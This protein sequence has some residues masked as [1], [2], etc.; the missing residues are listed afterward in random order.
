MERIQSF[1]K[2]PERYKAIVF[3]A[4]QIN[5][6]Q[7]TPGNISQH[8]RQWMTTTDNT[9][10]AEN[11]S[12]LGSVS[13]YGATSWKCNKFVADAYASTKG[14]GI[15][16]KYPIKKDR[17]GQRWCPQANELASLKNFTNFPLEELV[18]IAKD[19]KS[20]VEINEYDNNGNAVAKYRLEGQIFRKYVKQRRNW[21]QTKITKQASEL[22]PGSTAN[23]GDIVSFHNV[24]RGVSGHTGLYLGRDLFISA[25]NATVG[26]GILSIKMH[27][28]PKAWDKYDQITFR[29]FKG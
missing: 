24:E 7:L 17:R 1:E 3:A 26:V 2:L 14:A 12:R 16:N 22:D 15:K 27:L 28:E 29:S 11:K 9:T 19:G 6:G 18:R 5:M 21:Q 23:M 4:E 20:I 10:G 8:D 25:L 13:R